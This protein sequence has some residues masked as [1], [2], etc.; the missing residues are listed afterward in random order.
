MKTTYDKQQVDEIR[1]KLAE[2]FNADNN[3]WKFAALQYL[4]SA[5]EEI[6]DENESLWFML[7]EEKKSKPGTEH[8]EILNKLV[9]DRLSY[10]K[11]LQ[12]NKGEA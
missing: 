7:D 9:A 4:L 10:L 8:T 3:D 11:L 5:I 1:T 2:E 12:G 6:V